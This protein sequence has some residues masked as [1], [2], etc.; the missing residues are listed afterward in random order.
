MP[1]R[2]VLP[3]VHSAAGALLSLA[4]LL[5]LA[6][7]LIPA[8]QSQ[9]QSHAQAQAGQDGDRISH[10]MALM[11]MEEIVQIMREEGLAYGGE[12]GR[13]MLSG[14]GGPIWDQQVDRILQLLPDLRR[15]AG[16][17]PAH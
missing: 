12:L 2:R 13:G 15:S 1:L 9:A 16:G 7:A 3:L 4:L 14:E 17:D 10:L 11:G 5:G 6:A 8:A